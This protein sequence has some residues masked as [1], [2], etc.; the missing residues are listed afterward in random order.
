[1]KN[2]FTKEA[3]IGIITILS[4]SL[5]YIGVNYLKGINLFKPS[6][7]YTVVFDN[8]KDVTVSSPV[9]VEGFKVGLVREINYNYQT[10]NKISIEIS[11]EDEMKI[12]KGSYIAIVKNILGG[13]ELH[14]HLNKHVD[15]YYGSGDEIEGRLSVDM[16]ATVQDNLL[17]QVENLLP[18]IDSILGGLQTLIN[19]PALAQS[20]SSIQQTTAN[21]EKSTMHL[22][23]V[24]SKDVP[25]I[26]ENL[27]TITTDFSEVSGTLNGLEIDKTF[28]S[29]Q[30]TVSNLQLTTKKI[31]DTDNSMGL[32]LNDRQLYDN[33]NKTA[34]NASE[35][36]FDLKKNPKRYVH[37]SLF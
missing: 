10:N 33:L 36:M 19:H 20:L 3:K 31:N 22:N 12:N 8:V 21:L 24:L 11:L 35:L 5:L 4:L 16:F 9:L 23:T 34:T 18:K 37:F 2:V 32:L 26:V 30:Q 28:Q 13:A 14:I 6:N 27:K 7:H 25:F 15:G 29:I 1:M 17:P